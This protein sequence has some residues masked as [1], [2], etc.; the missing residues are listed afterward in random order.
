MDQLIQK[1]QSIASNVYPKN[2]TDNISD[3]ASG[4]PLNEILSRNNHYFL[5]YT[6][7]PEDTRL[8]L[9]N[10][11]RR[12]GVIITYEDT[13]GKLITEEYNKED[14]DDL[15]FKDSSNWVSYNNQFKGQIEISS[16]GYWIID[17]VKTQ[18]KAAVDQDVNTMN[19]TLE[20]IKQIVL[21]GNAKV[22]IGVNPTVIEKGVNSNVSVAWQ[23]TLGNATVDIQ[24]TVYKNNVQWAI[25]G[26]SKQ[27]TIN[28]STT[29]K[30]VAIIEGINVQA[31]AT[32]NAYY[33]IYTFISTQDS[34]TAI[35]DGATKQ[36]IV[37]TPRGQTYNYLVRD[38]N[39]YL[40]IVI[41][42]TMSINDATSAGYSV[43][44]QSIGTI[45]VSGKG[46]YKVYRTTQKIVMGS[47]SLLF[48]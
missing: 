25:S 20:F 43:G 13:Y 7:S 47:Y 4:Q 6:K 18:F 24:Y 48:S 37:S 39:S 30:V 41:P 26:T 10:S 21:S 22:T 29:Y 46:V 35:P 14:I 28:D 31:T 42:N 27:D 17:G 33:P 15:N 19:S 32:V 40:Y 9:I 36:N 1:K 5:T 23:G 34:I 3:K 44:M 45:N 12:K 11:L 2:F 16:D 8:T 38:Q